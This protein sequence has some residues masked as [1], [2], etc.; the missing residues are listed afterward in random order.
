MAASGKRRRDADDPVRSYKDG[1]VAYWT[2]GRAGVGQ[3]LWERTGSAARAE[4]RAVELREQLATSAGAGPGSGTTLDQLV[5]DCLDALRRAGRPE[6]TIRQYRSDWNSLVPEELGSLPCRSV[7]VFHWQRLMDSLV[8]ARVSE[9]RIASVVRTLNAVTMWGA[10][11][12]YF[13]ASEPWGSYTLRRAAVKEARQTARRKAGG[14][15]KSTV[16][17]SEC[18]RWD[19]IITYAE[20]MEAVLPRYGRRAVILA[21]ATGMR[22]GEVLGS[23]ADEWNLDTG[24]VQVNWQADRYSPWPAVVPPK[25]GK[26]RET[27]L[28]AHATNVAAE[29]IAD[30]HED[31]WLIPLPEDMRAEKWLAKFSKLTEEVDWPWSFHWTRHHWAS[32]SLAPTTAGG[33]GLPPAD[34]SRWLGH[35]NLST[36]LDTYI[37]PTSDAIIQ[38]RA[39]TA[40]PPS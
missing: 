38:A 1:R 35:A 5:Q 27:V 8:E 15:A 33:Y 23:R 25:G 21:A 2:G 14:K 26:T 17:L 39:A 22:M 40:E 29:A 11:R 36:T 28:W 3:R 20:A 37:Q 32:V 30:A 19:D 9:G 18:P 31:G 6:G 7:T 13:G 10:A 34:V 12:G 4:A 24:V 16:L